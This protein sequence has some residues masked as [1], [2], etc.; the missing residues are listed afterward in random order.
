MSVNVSYG[1]LKTSTDNLRQAFEQVG[2]VWDIIPVESKITGRLLKQAIVRFYDGEYQPGSTPDAA[3]VLPPP[4]D[5]EVRNVSDTA[6][7]AVDRLDRMEINGFRI[8]VT[9]PDNERP[10]QLHEWRHNDLFPINPFAE[11]PRTPDDD[12]RQGFMTGFKLG[13]KDGSKSQS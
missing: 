3:P 8:R 5:S 2:K 12:Y 11:P 7:A 13:L 6:K 9:M 1:T 10:T 4:T